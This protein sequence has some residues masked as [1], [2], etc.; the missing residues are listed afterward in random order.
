MNCLLCQ[1]DDGTHQLVTTP[2]FYHC[3]HCHSVFRSSDLLLSSELEKARYLLHENDVLDKGYQS[4]VSPLVQAVENSLPISAHG[5]DFGAGPAPVAAQLLSEQGYD[6][7]FW[8]PFFHNNPE[9][10]N[11]TYDFIICCETIEHF[12]RPLEEFQRMHRLL[13]PHGKLFCMTDLLPAMSTFEDWYYKNDMTHVIFYSEANLQWIKE[14]VGFSELSIQDRI[15]TF[16][17]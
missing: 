10:L 16:S 12:Y 15:I 14:T 1:K 9:V 3:S 8:D 17:K 2:Q 11:T 6:I 7:R 4:F 13:Q 5:L